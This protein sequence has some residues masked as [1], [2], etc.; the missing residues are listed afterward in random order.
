LHD[1]W[2]RLPDE[3]QRWHDHALLSAVLREETTREAERVREAIAE[4]A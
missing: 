3:T 2:V 1:E 4:Q